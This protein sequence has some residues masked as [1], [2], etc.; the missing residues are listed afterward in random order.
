MPSE[1]AQSTLTAPGAAGASVTANA[2]VSPSGADASAT[3]SAGVPRA[4]GAGVP[5][6]PA[7]ACA[8]AAASPVGPTMVPPLSARLLLSTSTEATG[9]SAAVTV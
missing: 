7:P 6:R 5:E 8:S 3:D 1:V 2:S 4:V 9:P